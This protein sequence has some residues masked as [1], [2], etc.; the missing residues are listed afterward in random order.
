MNKTEAVAIAAIIGVLSAEA[1]FFF[2]TPARTIS[3]DMV[4]NGITAIIIVLVL[5]GFF[6][7]FTMGDR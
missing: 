7:L 6:W 5:T 2:V 4:V 3:P 1:F